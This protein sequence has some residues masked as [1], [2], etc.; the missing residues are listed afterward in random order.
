[1]DTELLTMHETIKW[2]G[3]SSKK[4]TSF[5]TILWYEEERSFSRGTSLVSPL[6]TRSVEAEALDQVFIGGRE[7]IDKHRE[8]ELANLITWLKTCSSCQSKPNLACVT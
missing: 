1:M 5:C 2:E 8:V 7:C 3:E 6:L 4:T